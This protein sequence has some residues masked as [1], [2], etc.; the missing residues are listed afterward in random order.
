MKAPSSE[1]DLAT[2]GTEFFDTQA[3]RWIGLYDIKPSFRDRLD[4]FTSTLEG[5]QPA[6]ARVLDFGCGPG[7][8]SMALAARGYQMTGVDGAPRMIELART[9]SARRGLHGTRFDVVAAGELAFPAESFDAVVC[10]SVIEYV[11]DDVELIGELA[12][13]IAPGGHLLVSV[14][15]SESVVGF[16][17]SALSRMAA[18]TSAE[19][20]RHLSFSLRRYR[21]KTFARTLEAAGFE[22][23][24]FTYFESAIPGRLGVTLSRWRRVGVMLLVSGRKRR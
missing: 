4:L 11:P 15:Q 8:I 23:L 24:T 5:V 14:P 1:M 3:D 21:R 2:T 18:Y 16:A 9:E 19:R 10:S 7:V 13:V 6:P 20:R 22:S 17:E 12:Q